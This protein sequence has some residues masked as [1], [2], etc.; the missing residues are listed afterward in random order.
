MKRKL[1]TKRKNDKPKICI[2]DKI[3]FKA[4]TVT[5]DKED[6][7]KI[8][9]GSSQQEDTTFV[10]I[11]AP[12]IGVPQ[13]TRQTLT[14]IRGEFNSNTA[15]VGDFNTPLTPVDRSSKQNQ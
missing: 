3:C 6:H 10:N 15:I 9:K 13:Y 12:S 11:Y 14:G 7:Y 4:K 1:E 5:K 2:S 8:I